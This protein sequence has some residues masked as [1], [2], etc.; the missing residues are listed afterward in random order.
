MADLILFHH[1]LGLTDGVEAFAGLVRDAGHRVV[2]PDLYGGTTFDTIEE[3]VAHAE[4]TGFEEI[5][6]TAEAAA[7]ILPGQVVYAG[8]SL[9]ALAAH[10]LAQTRPGCNGALLYHHGDVPIETFAETWPSGVDIQI[11]VSE[12]DE[13]F[14]RAVVEEFIEEAGKC[15]RADL[16]T[17]P[18]SSHLFTDSSLP[19]YDAESASLVVRRTLGFLDRRV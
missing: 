6:A 12:E 14:E 8:F 5:L 3:G 11:H 7:Q 18:G 1:A 17:Y 19:E 2:V 4:E 15:A 10:K 13:F 9:G 16:F